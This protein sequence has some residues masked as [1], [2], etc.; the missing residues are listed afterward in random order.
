MTSALTTRSGAVIPSPCRAEAMR[1][2]TLKS[3]S[4]GVDVSCARDGDATC[5]ERLKIPG[6]SSAHG[7]RA[8]N[9]KFE[10]T[11]G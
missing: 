9:K 2:L 6:Q 4:V 1:G 3:K 10:R 7:E 5:L 11:P 8:P